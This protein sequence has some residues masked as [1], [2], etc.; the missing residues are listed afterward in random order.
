MIIIDLRHFV[1]DVTLV[2]RFQNMSINLGY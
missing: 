2:L 1:V